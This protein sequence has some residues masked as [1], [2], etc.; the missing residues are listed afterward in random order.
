MRKWWI[1]WPVYFGLMGFVL[2][3]SFFFGL[4]GRNVTE[5]EI[6]SQEK[7]YTSAEKTNSNKQE[8]D[9]ALA[10]Y[11]LWLMAF[12]GVLAFATIG[13]G[14]AT[15]M[16]FGT[17]E[18]QFKFAIRSGSVKPEVCRHRSKSQ[19]TLLR[20]PIRAPK[21]LLSLREPTS[22]RSSSRPVQSNNVSGPLL[23]PKMT[24]FQHQ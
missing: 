24:M 17:G 14:I 10:Y 21:L 19:L 23:T 22:I 11:T 1:V 15:V 3:A 2:G 13:L 5:S 12:T 16:L 6:A 7:H 20:P 18:K 4:Y 9:A 8:T